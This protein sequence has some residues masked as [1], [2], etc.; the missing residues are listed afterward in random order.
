[1]MLT[2]I[3]V[4][5]DTRNKKKSKTIFRHDFRKLVVLKIAYLVYVYY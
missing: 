4:L 3:F 1:M 5:V 2:M